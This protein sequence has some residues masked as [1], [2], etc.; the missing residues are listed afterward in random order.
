MKIIAKINEIEVGIEIKMVPPDDKGIKA[1][2]TLVFGTL[3]NI[4]GFTIR[5]SKYKL[6]DNKFNKYNYWVA[7]PCVVRP[8]R[9]FHN[10]FP[11]DKAWWKEIEDQILEHFINELIPVIDK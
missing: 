7:A 2:V 4:P 10:F 1:R 3:F 6:N 8:G 5:D 9:I 11:L